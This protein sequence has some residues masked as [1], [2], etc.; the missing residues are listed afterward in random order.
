MT[1]EIILQLLLGGIL[2]IAGQLVRV[3][4]G[5]KKAND[6]AISKNLTLKQTF[7]TS[8]LVVSILLGFVAGVLAMVSLTT[9]KC[10]FL[11]TDTK[12]TIMALIVAGYAG[13]DFIEG[14]MKK[15]S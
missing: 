6:E 9:F 7:D 8:R 2:G 13:T 3:V 15:S 4:V 5:L 10:D 1:Q 11:Q 14:F 12:K